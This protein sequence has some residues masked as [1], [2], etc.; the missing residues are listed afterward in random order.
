MW[1]CTKFPN[2]SETFPAFPEEIHCIYKQKNKQKNT[3]VG[4]QN[5]CQQIRFCTKLYLFEFG[6]V[7]CMLSTF[8]VS[9]RIVANISE[10]SLLFS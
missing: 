2:C 1:K 7:C 3:K 5:F 9:S 8:H 6:V 4:S 10:S